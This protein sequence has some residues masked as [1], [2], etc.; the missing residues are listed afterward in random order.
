MFECECVDTLDIM[1]F[2][3]LNQQPL[4]LIYMLDAFILNDHSN[5]TNTMRNDA[6]HESGQV[7]R[8]N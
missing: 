2:L 1:L 8:I 3:L 6:D 5:L 7:I 4:D